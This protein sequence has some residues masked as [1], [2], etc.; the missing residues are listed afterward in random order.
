MD[1]H[2]SLH[3]GWRYNLVSVSAPL[4]RLHLVV[5]FLGA[6]RRS[7]CHPGTDFN[8]GRCP[9]MVLDHCQWEQGVNMQKL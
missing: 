1:H 9:V 8:R 3:N 6:E 7:F 4:E 2:Q 5:I